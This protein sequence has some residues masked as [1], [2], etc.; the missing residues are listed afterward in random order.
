MRTII[1]LLFLILIP[2]PLYA[3]EVPPTVLYFED[4]EAQP[5]KYHFTV[6]DELYYETDDDGYYIFNNTV[7]EIEVDG[8]VIPLKV[9][10]YH[11]IHVEQPM[12]DNIPDNANIEAAQATDKETTVKVFTPAFTPSEPVH[13]DLSSNDKKIATRELDNGT[14]TFNNLQPNTTYTVTTDDAIA[15][16]S[17]KQGET[18]HLTVQSDEPMPKA[19]AVRVTP[20]RSP[21]KQR[22]TVALDDDSAQDNKNNRSDQDIKKPKSDKQSKK[23]RYQY[24]R[25]TIYPEESIKKSDATETIPQTNPYPNHRIQHSTQPEFEQPVQEAFIEDTTKQQKVSYNNDFLPHNKKQQTGETLP[26]TGETYNRTFLSI[27]LFVYGSAI[28][29]LSRLIK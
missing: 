18:K 1:A 20:Q 26:D 14:A 4:D 13:V 16:I 29:Y 10:Q 17:I 12:E 8:Q 19:R 27:L 22:L 25:T 15:P 21:Q 5:L 6:N 28:I 9:G 3:A 2:L 11:I 7:N 24:T 23:K